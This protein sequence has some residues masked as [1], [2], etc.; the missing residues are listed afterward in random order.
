MVPGT[1]ANVVVSV[2]L[3]THHVTGYNMNDHL[4]DSF[5]YQTV[6]TND[7]EDAYV[8]RIQTR[9]RYF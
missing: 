6:L 7:H 5:T 1:L 3:I 2:L 9:K 4:V 8:V